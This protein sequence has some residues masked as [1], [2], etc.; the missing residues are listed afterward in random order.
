MFKVGVAR[1]I[2]PTYHAGFERVPVKIDLEAIGSDVVR[3][4]REAPTRAVHDLTRGVAETDPGTASRR[5]A[6]HPLLTT[7]TAP[8]LLHTGGLIG[9]SSGGDG[10]D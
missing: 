8:L 7:T 6:S 1:Q 5:P 3:Y 4:G 10:G 9:Q 2:H